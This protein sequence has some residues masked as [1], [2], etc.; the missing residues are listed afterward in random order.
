MYYDKRFSD[1]CKKLGLRIKYLREEQKI[2]IKEL[3]QKTKIRVEYLNK[4]EKGN[5]Y[6]ICINKHLLKIATGLKIK[7]S[8][9]LDFD[10]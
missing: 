7:L 10:S 9:L 2:T 6:G 3:S 8:K 5:A 4:I 1:M